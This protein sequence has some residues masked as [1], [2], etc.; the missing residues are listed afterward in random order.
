MMSSRPKRISRELI[1]AFFLLVIGGV[2]APSTAETS[3]GDYVTSMLGRSTDES[4]SG[5]EI[6]RLSTVQVIDRTRRVPE[7]HRP[8]AGPSCSSEQRELPSP[9]VPLSLSQSDAFG[10]DMFMRLWP[11]LSSDDRWA[12]P[13]AACPL[14]RTFFIERPPR[15]PLLHLI[16]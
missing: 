8:C 11:D 1:G 5:S 9:C 15:C 3:C 12:D 13:A 7:R 4:L 6:M 10:V 2:T 16:D 14:Q